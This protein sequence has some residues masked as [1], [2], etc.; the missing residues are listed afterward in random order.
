MVLSGLTRSEIN[1]LVNN[2]LNG[3]IGSHSR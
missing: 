2:V 1:T 3:I